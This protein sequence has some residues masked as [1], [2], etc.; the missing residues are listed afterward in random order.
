MTDVLSVIPYTIISKGQK[1]VKYLL[2][3]GMTPAFS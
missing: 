2:K 1:K 3:P